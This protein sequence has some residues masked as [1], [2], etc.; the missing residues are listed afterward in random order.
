MTCSIQIPSLATG[1]SDQEALMAGHTNHGARS[2]CEP[3]QARAPHLDAQRAAARDVQGDV[4]KEGI[5][6]WAVRERGPPLRQHGQLGLLQAHPVRHHRPIG[7][8][9]RPVVER[10]VPAPHLQPQDS[11]MY[12]TLL[13]CCCVT[14]QGMAVQPCTTLGSFIAPV[15]SARSLHGAQTHLG[16]QRGHEGLV[17]EALADVALRVAP[18]PRRE[19]AQ[20]PQ[21]RRRAGGHKARRHDRVHQRGPQCPALPTGA[22]PVMLDQVMYS[23]SA[24]SLWPAAVA[25]SHMLGV[26]CPSDSDMHDMHGVQ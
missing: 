4:R 8:Q 1:K 13:L 5:T 10:G 23:G 3:V 17:V 9:P 14:H 15:K 11:C 22:V 24:A 12:H 6:K 7:E 20:P 2:A 21:Q 16:V 26:G 18:V 25:S 19:R